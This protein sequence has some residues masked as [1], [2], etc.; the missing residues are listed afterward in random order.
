MVGRKLPGL[1]GIGPAV[2]VVEGRLRPVKI[3]Q[4]IPIALAVAVNPEIPRLGFPGVVGPDVPIGVRAGLLPGRGDKPRIVDGGVADDVVEEDLQPA[5]VGLGKQAAG[6][7]VR[8]VARRDAVVVPDVIAGV[9]ERRIEERIQPDR[10]DAQA[11]HIVQLR[12]DP[13]QIADAVAVGIEEGLGIDLVDDG[14]MDPRRAVRDDIP[15]GDLRSLRETL[16]ARERLR[17]TNWPGG[18]FEEET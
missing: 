9:V 5:L 17:A 14:V 2:A 11:L 16:R 10:V 12:D 7:L 18:K 3:A 1:G 6:I 15:A 13:R 4:E 8:A